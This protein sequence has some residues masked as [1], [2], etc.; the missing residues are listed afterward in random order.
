MITRYACDRVPADNVRLRVAE[1]LRAHRI[2]P[3]EVCGS[4]GWIE[5]D[6][7]THTIRALVYGVS[8]DGIGRVYDR[9]EVVEARGE[10]P[11]APW[12][13][14][15]H[16]WLDT[17]GASITTYAAPLAEWYRSDD[18]PRTREV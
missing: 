15:R 4:P 3:G 14:A 8:P 6:A 5:V 16:E 12:P 13:V 11:P 18:P 1:W 10:G 2:E 9:F 7:D 17:A